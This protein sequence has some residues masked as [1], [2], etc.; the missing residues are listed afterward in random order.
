MSKI[1]LKSF[2]HSKSFDNLFDYKSTFNN[3]QSFIID[4]NF[5]FFRTSNFTKI[6]PYTPNELPL[7]LNNRNEYI[8]DIEKIMNDN[9]SLYFFVSKINISYHDYRLT[10]KSK[11]KQ[12]PNFISLYNFNYTKKDLTLKENKRKINLSKHNQNYY[13]LNIGDVIK[14]GRISL[15]LTKIHLEQNTNYITH[16]ETFIETKLNKDRNSNIKS[17]NIEKNIYNDNNIIKT[18]SK[19]QKNYER[20]IMNT[21]GD[22]EENL[23][24]SKSDSEKKDICRICFMSEN[25]FS[26]P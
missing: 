1:F 8:F 5:S 23:E 19:Y 10:S 2:I 13:E 17:N 12:I 9:I 15:I 16:C 21:K 3:Y 22:M 20:I 11:K 25:E 14:I 18:R 4:K 26:S 6:K 24:E 7:T